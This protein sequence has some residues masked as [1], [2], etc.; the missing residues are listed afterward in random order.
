MDAYPAHGKWCEKDHAKKDGCR[1][2]ESAGGKA[3]IRIQP[4][5]ADDGVEGGGGS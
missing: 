4:A 5:G 3:D 1:E 2:D